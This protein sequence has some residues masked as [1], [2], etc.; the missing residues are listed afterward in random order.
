[1]SKKK[2]LKVRDVAKD[3]FSSGVNINDPKFS[4]L[5]IRIIEGSRL[6]ASDVETGKSD[7]VCFLWVGP[8][9]ENPKVPY[10]SS[11]EA[12][13]V[14]NEFSYQTTAVC[15]TTIDPIW[16]EDI[17]F[18][19]DMSDVNQAI[20]QKCVIYVRDE[21]KLP[22][23][24][25]TTY[26]ELGMLEFTL[27][28]IISR[29]KAQRS[30]IVRSAQWYDLKKS[31][32]MRKVE[33]RLKLTITMIFS[34]EDT[35]LI[36][37]QLPPPSPG[38]VSGVVPSHQGV[39][40]LLQSTFKDPS[41]AND[42]GDVR[43]S[44][45]SLR[46]SRSDLP[47][48]SMS[49]SPGRPGMSSSDSVASMVSYTR[50]KSAK[51]V[52]K[53]DNGSRA[54]RPVSA[55]NHRYGIDPVEEEEDAI[56]E[57]RGNEDAEAAN[58]AEADDEEESELIILPKKA[59]LPPIQKQH[60]ASNDDLLAS[61]APPQGDE[62]FLGG[63]INDIGGDIIQDLGATAIEKTF[64]VLG[65]TAQKLE[66]ELSHGAHTAITGALAKAG[67][68][69]GRVSQNAA[70]TLA[71]VS[72]DALANLNDGV[73]LS[74]QISKGA[75][76]LLANGRDSPF[77]PVD[78]AESGISAGIGLLA[79]KLAKSTT[80]SANASPRSILGKDIPSAN[81][82]ASPPTASRPAGG[83]LEE[84]KL[85]ISRPAPKDVAAAKS[86]A[87]NPEA[88]EKKGSADKEGLSAKQQDDLLRM[89]APPK[90]DCLSK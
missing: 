27:K 72:K 20:N 26:D 22:D 58:S 73:V 64:D 36:S 78:A 56:A 34:P 84:N 24:E 87:P 79:S 1:M 63:L 57:E 52:R 5:I 37:Q 50:P 75:G 18:E 65:R 44:I 43:M 39:G 53:S 70:K 61:A 21:D 80:A 47:R 77:T 17:V 55:P 3:H 51:I 62:S 38:A 16:N 86:V 32:G 12:A 54:L 10:S 69:A 11:A 71:S 15:P 89:G 42:N 85:V 7:P 30:S 31:P 13:D 19:L 9:S 46:G 33:G 76:T 60:K 48:R 8:I 40:Y 2:G 67:E 29:G 74:K 81:N 82:V 90:G 45:N 35:D 83:L 41:L 28:E 23:D 6:L 66:Q 14:S 59:K 68:A 25:G 49:T 88:L 4:R